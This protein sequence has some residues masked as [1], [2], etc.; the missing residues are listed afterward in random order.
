M[1]SS[2]DRCSGR[3]KPFWSELVCYH[4]EFRILKGLGIVPDV[5]SIGDTMGPREIAAYFK[6]EINAGLFTRDLGS[7]WL[8][9]SWW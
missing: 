5:I 8:I 3:E 1:V 4:A 6:N 9:P 2:R 7:R